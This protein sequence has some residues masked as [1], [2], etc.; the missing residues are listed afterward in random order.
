MKLEFE[1]RGN[2]G[3]GSYGFGVG[4]AY[5]VLRCCSFLGFIPLLGPAISIAC[6]ITWIIYWVK[7]AGYSRELT[8]PQ[9]VAVVPANPNM[10]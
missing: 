7:I 5:S 3:D 9:S 10:G 8:N 2:S 4:L 1:S 6:L